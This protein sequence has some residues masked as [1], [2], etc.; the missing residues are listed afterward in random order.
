MASSP[1]GSRFLRSLLSA[2]FSLFL[3][4]CGAEEESRT[5]PP[6]PPIDFPLTVDSANVDHAARQGWYE[7]GWVAEALNTQG[8][9]GMDLP[10]AP[11]FGAA[12][13]ATDLGNLPAHLDG[14]ALAM[15]S[16]CVPVITGYNGAGDLIDTDG[17]GIPNDYKVD[18]G[19][20]CVSEIEGGVVRLTIS[21]SRR[22][23]DTD[24][25][26]RSFKVTTKDLVIVVEYLDTHVVHTIGLSGV[27]EGSFEGVGAHYA[28]TSTVREHSLDPKAGIDDDRYR[29]IIESA[30]FVPAAGQSLALHA[31]LPAGTLTYQ[32]D[33]GHMDPVDPLLPTRLFYHF[34][35]SATMALEYSPACNGGDFVAGVL[36]GNLNGG[37][38]TGF[39]L[40]WNGCTELPARQLFGYM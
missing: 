27:E 40:T 26:F 37:E 29:Q 16:E 31:S 7:S 33:L 28:Q 10:M 3:A 17:D 36:R 14:P 1:A 13:W 4:A 11:A 35:M 8:P 32:A 5:P 20:A 15:V 23:Q 6:E 12:R 25:G 22:L 2:L 18:Y 21:G 34:T 30:D 39:Q 38:E 19:E 24:L 9:R